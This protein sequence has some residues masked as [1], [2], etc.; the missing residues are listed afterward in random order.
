MMKKIMLVV[1]AVLASVT[2]AFAQGH[3]HIYPKGA[4]SGDFFIE[5]MKQNVGQPKSTGNSTGYEVIV[6]NG[7]SFTVADI[8]PGQNFGNN[9]TIG[10][11]LL[12]NGSLAPCQWIVYDEPCPVEKDIFKAKNASDG[13]LPV[14]MPV[15]KSI[16]DRLKAL[17]DKGK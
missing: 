14:T 12:R 1:T 8:K 4:N 10:G 13:N 5:S 17:E 9:T 3:I 15:V 7:C 11:V 2:P 6:D 16:N